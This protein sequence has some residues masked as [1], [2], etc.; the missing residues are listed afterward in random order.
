MKTQKSDSLNC[1][2]E[3]NFENNPPED[4]D[5]DLENDKGSIYNQ[6]VQ[7]KS[8]P[9][10]ITYDK[11]TF[12]AL[13]SLFKT[14]DEINLGNLQ[15]QAFAKLKEYKESTTL[16]LQYVIENQKLLDVNIE[17]MS[18]IIIVPHTGYFTENCACSVINL[19]KIS[20]SSKEIS[21]EVVDWKFNGKYCTVWKKRKLTL[22]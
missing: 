9:L 6:K 7:F 21:Q 20:V 18:S 19:G 3:F 12:Q 10:E 13:S 22:S 1:L 2:L 16:N 14:P 5:A 17:L 15:Q 11:Y 8:S 4:P